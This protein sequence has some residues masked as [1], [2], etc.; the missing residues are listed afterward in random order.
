MTRRDFLATAGVALQRS[1]PPPN[2]VIILCD[3]LGYG[4]L[5]SYG[6]AHKTPNLDSFARE[7]MRFTHYISANPVCSPSR[8]AL[9]TGRY[10]TRVG[11]PRVLG[12]LDTTGL[13]LDETT[14]AQSLKARSYKTACIGKW[15]LGRPTEY[16]P[17]NRGFDEYFGIPYSNDMKPRVLMRNLEV[18]EDETDVNLLTK[19]YTERAVDF[20]E[21]SKGAPFFLYLAHTMPHIPLGASPQFRGTSPLGLFGDVIRELDWSVGEIVKTL[22]RHGLEKNTLVLFTSDNGPWYQGSPGRLRGRKTSTYEGGV[23]EP[24]LARMPGRIPAGQV[25]S[26]LV[27]AMDFT[28]T[29]LKLSGA[30]ASGKPMD[31]ID[32]WPLLSGK[33]Q[34]LDRDVLLYFDNVHL[35]CARWGRWKLHV[36]RYDRGF[37]ST[38]AQDTRTNYPLV[39]P[40]LYDV[41]LDVDEGCDVAAD[42]PDIVRHMVA[43]I[44]ELLPG[45]PEVIQKAWATT[46]ARKNLETRSGARPRPGK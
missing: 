29:F 31:G 7:G 26:N 45:F 18:I 13:N 2:L 14:L 43:R 39:K 33:E 8:A 36:S 11:V 20:I 37:Y 25:C 15:H 28:P 12:P 32:I 6:G 10:P 41:T 46:K 34:S 30:P 42:H 22:S 1:T 24:F 35:Q 5:A 19:R 16:M 23:R 38:I 27:S 4:D 3:D 21:R 17:A 9:L 40:E 44:E